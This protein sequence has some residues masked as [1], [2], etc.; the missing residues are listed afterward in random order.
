MKR[1][2]LR[3]RIP[4]RSR[5]DRRRRVNVPRCANRWCRRVA[6]VGELCTSCA[7]TR[8]D[9][10]FSRLIRGRDRRCIVAAWFPDLE[11]SGPLECSHLL[12]RAHRGVRW[13]PGNAVAACAF[14]HGFTTTHP[15]LWRTALAGN[16]YDLA[17]LRARAVANRHP[18]IPDVIA[19]L[20]RKAAA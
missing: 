3:R 16:G 15:L 20:Q 4:L 19:D 11:C 7:I 10:L 5:S 13:D 8:A 17:A 14:H 12:G 9:T 1:S 18:W 2:P 6:R